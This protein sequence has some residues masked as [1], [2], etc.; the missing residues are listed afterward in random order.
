M[1]Y[2]DYS[3]TTPPKPEIVQTVQDVLTR[4]F[5]NPSSLHHLGVEAE[6]LL[7]KAREVAAHSLEVH[8]GEIV[9]TS[10][11]TESN[12]LAI[13]GF[14]RKYKQR[15][16][17]LITTEIEHASVYE[18][19][20][21]LENEGFKVTYL[22]A[23]QNGCITPEQVEHAL[24][25]ETLLVSVMHVNN[26]V[27]AIQPV[28]A[29]GQL[30]RTYPRTAFHVDAVQSFGKISLAP[31]KM[32]IDLLSVSAHKIGGPKGIGLLF[33]R[34]GLQL[35]P[36][37]AGGGQENG[38]RSGTENVPYIVALA[39]AMR[40]AKENR[41][42]TEQRLRT[43]RK[44][45][46]QRLESL[47]DIVI[48]G[49]QD[50]GLSAPHIVHLRMP[51]IQSEVLVHALEKKEIYIS[52]KSACSSARREP[53]RVLLSMGCSKDEA[54]S[55][56]RIS[57]CAEHTESEIDILTDELGQAAAQLKKVE[58]GKIL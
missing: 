30:L 37:F 31:Q 28:E 23:D 1:L 56:I 57:L 9:F 21:Q 27:G 35:E 53:S 52:T 25:D 14:A 36:L 24:T 22:P 19:F 45:L 54:L 7:Q 11:G 40:I 8:E 10:G 2:F 41:P 34:K 58:A 51:G 20:R 13:K 39:K 38:L 3:A 6:R 4:I 18:A 15:G 44:H 50:P 32:G 48:S 43:L 5:G 17:H 29:I 16:N 47:D 42:E 49:A 33:K 46:V 12:N 26:E 55:G